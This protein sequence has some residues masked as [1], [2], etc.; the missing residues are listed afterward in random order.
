MTDK[1]ATS[2]S[3]PPSR[4]FSMSL[5]HPL[6]PSKS[7]RP[8]PRS[9]YASPQQGWR[10]TPLYPLG[11]LRP[12]SAWRTTPSPTPHAPSL[13][14]SS[15]PSNAEA[16]SPTNASPSQGDVLTSSR[17]Q[18]TQ[19]RLKSAASEATTPTSKYLPAL[20][21][22]GDESTS[23]YP[24]TEGR[25]FSRGGFDS[26]GMERSSPE[27]AR[28]QTS[29]NT[30]S[31]FTSHQTTQH[32]PPPYS[33][34]G[35]SNSSKLTGEPTTPWLRRRVDSNTQQPSQRWSDTAATTHTEPSS[36]WHAEPSP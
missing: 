32:A 5:T 7:S 28:E 30:W 13:T 12:S 20:S 9:E 11:Q 15:R 23:K 25:T 24:P 26:W 21:K 22:T 17:G 18:Y 35:S 33:P 2:P 36:K 10:T 4:R 16:Q 6:H 1:P 27:P 31:P 34:P 19:G 3:R 8:H 14:A 29:Q